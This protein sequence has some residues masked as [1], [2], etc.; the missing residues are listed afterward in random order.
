MKT[1][2]YS[3]LLF[4]L[5]LTCLQFI[6]CKKDC[7]PNNPPTGDTVDLGQEDK[8]SLFPYKDFDT[9]M[10]IK[11]NLDTVIFLGGKIEN[12]Y[13]TALNGDINCPSLDKLQYMQLVFTNNVYGNIKLYENTLPQ[14][15]GYN[16]KYSI[17][18]SD[19]TYGTVDAGSVFLYQDSTQITIKG[20]AYKKVYKFN[21]SS[22]TD[23]L[24]FVHNVG[25]IKIIYK[26]DTY[27]KLP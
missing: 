5:I 2:I 21:N 24:Y 16:T 19:R 20:V 18:F 27:E 13:N 25:V 14:T 6:A 15:N 8:I 22:T 7:D 1:K 12:G 9:I 10:F 3:V 23:N 4:A 11:N 26:G 17:S